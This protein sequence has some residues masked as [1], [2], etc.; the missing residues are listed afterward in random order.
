LALNIKSQ[1]ASAQVV[2]SRGDVQINE[3]LN[4]IP[5][6]QGYPVPNFAP[7]PL[8][9]PSSFNAQSVGDVAQVDVTPSGGPPNQP[10]TPGSTSGPESETP[11]TSYEG[12]YVA[13]VSGE[14]DLVPG[15]TNNLPDV[16]VRDR[17]TGTTER[18]SLNEDGSQITSKSLYDW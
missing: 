13:F 4:S 5:I 8:P 6:N 17:L 15:D 16:F 7:S 18:V 3:G 2:D 14:S 11:S 1:L 9:G 10:V 12:R